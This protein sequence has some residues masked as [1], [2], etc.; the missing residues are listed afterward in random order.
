MEIKKRSPE[1]ALVFLTAYSEYAVDAF[2]LHASGYIMK[3]I[4]EEQFAAEVDYALSGKRTQPAVH[5]KVQTFGGFDIFVDGRQVAF[6]QAKCKAF[7]T[8]TLMR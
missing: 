3:P 5:I 8:G 4:L 2:K 6:K 1:T 7:L